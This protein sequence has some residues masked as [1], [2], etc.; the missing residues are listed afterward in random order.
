MFPLNRRRMASQLLPLL[1]VFILMSCGFD[2]VSEHRST[3]AS[4]PMLAH[5][6]PPPVNMP[7]TSFATI[8]ASGNP[9]VPPDGSPFVQLV[10]E[11]RAVVA[12]GSVSGLVSA[13]Q[14]HI[15]VTR[16]DRPAIEVRYRLPRGLQLQS[17]RREV[18][19]LSDLHGPRPQDQRILV[20]WRGGL[21]L[22]QVELAGSAPLIGELG[23]NLRLVQRAVSQDSRAPADAAVD[24]QAE[25]DPGV[26]VRIATPTRVES[27]FG[28]FDVFVARSRVDGQT[29][30]ASDSLYVLSAWVV[31]ASR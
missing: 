11:G 18:G 23:S 26:P 13:A 10:S 14:G 9:E 19:R 31:H 7:E 24:F 22:A 15:E 1:A 16:T 5:L 25:G 6:V 30:T 20:R 21:L 29:K 17:C 28:A 2:S 3:R 4:D 8:A 12:E 27:R